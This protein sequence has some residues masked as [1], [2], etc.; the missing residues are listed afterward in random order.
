MVEEARFSEVRHQFGKLVTSGDARQPTLNWARFNLAICG[1]VL[2]KGNE[3]QQHFADMGGA[4]P[5]DDSVLVSDAAH[6]L[7]SKLST[8]LGSRGAAGL[9]VES[10]GYGTTDEELM[11]YLAHGVSEW[12]E[13]DAAI[14]VDCLNYFLSH[15]QDVVPVTASS[16]TPLDWIQLYKPMVERRFSND[17]RIVES[18]TK[19]KTGEDLVSLQKAL[20]AVRDARGAMTSGGTFVRTLDAKEKLIQ[21][22]LARLRAED[23][24]GRMAEAKELRERELA[25]LGEVVEALP[26]LIQGYDYSRAVAVLDEMHFETPEVQ[27]AVDG[28][29][30]LF[31]EAA[32]FMEQIFADVRMSPYGGDLT[33]QSGPRITGKVME[34]SLG[35]VRVSIDRGEIDLPT[36]SLTPESLIEMAQHYL[37][38]ITDS[39]DYY[40]RQERLA[41]FARVNG[42]QSLSAVVAARLMEENRG[43]RTRWMKVLQGGI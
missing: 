13:G 30:Y 31:A 21:S 16:T 9:K 20:K 29:R 33:Q 2:G 3:A 18:I 28:R 8:R 12:Y 22:R 10:L 39:T 35:M 38:Q 25:Q 27:A 23:Q 6:S 34:A 41:V 11:G 19:L 32:A 1:Y 17:I 15:L 7:F 4:I 43:F 26:A 40:T 14:G 36:D 37:S 5:D 42:L 24:K